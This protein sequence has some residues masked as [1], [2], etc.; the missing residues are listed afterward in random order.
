MSIHRSRN[1]NSRLVNR[2]EDICTSVLLQAHCDEAVVRTLLASTVQ[3]NN[4]QG[5]F[6]KK[7]GVRE[8][9]SWT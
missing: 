8:Y 4:Y 9:K 3:P 6:G 5:I 2:E 1:K 7:K